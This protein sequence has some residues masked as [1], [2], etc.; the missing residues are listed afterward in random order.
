MK[1]RGLFCC[2]SVYQLFNAIVLKMKLFGDLPSDL[3]LT[4]HTDFSNIIEPL[5]KSNLFESV[6]PVVCRS[7]QNAFWDKT[8]EEKKRIFKNPSL[9]L[10][11]FPTNQRYTDMFIP[12]D[13]I[14]WKLL[15]YFQVNEGVLPTIHFFEEGLR[16]YTMDV[17]A[18]EKREIYNDGFYQKKSFTQQIADYFVYEPELFFMEQPPYQLKS[19][20][21]L[22]RMDEPLCRV[23]NTVF[24]T[25]KL[26]EERFIFFEESYLGDKKIANDFQL[27]LE[28]AN[29]VGKE[30]I[31]VK[32]HPRNTIDRF[33]K[34]GYRVMQQWN[35]PWE[36]QLLL[37]D[38]SSKI[39]VTISSTASVT[40]FLLCDQSVNAI[41]LLNLF[42][43]LSPLL[44]D[45]GFKRC[46]DK[47]I[48]MCNKE[49]I[50]VHKPNQIE[51]L[52][53]IL[54]FLNAKERM[55]EEQ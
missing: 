4:E 19:I 45:R 31:I 25:D 37:N 30:N 8:L 47:L 52:K 34:K 42:Q 21:K 35:C 11:E 9:L 40:P 29:F 5:R 50:M 2:E 6:L 26:P 24:P 23:M 10:G 3:F 16:A 13:H 39:F 43:G 44:E 12:I 33:T 14:Y 27:F 36:V 7:H 41:H 28:V 53:E 48:D 15:Y 55:R 1:Q 22:S 38:V 18:A 54:A 51:E 46:Y 32:R 17:C 49:K 20:P